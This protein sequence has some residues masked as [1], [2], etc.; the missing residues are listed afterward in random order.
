MERLYELDILIVDLVSKIEHQYKICK[1]Y[2]AD[3]FLKNKN[4]I[5]SLEN[6]LDKY[7][8]EYESLKK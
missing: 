7:T 2:D 4:Y 6:K 3:Y 8:S 1:L 5:K